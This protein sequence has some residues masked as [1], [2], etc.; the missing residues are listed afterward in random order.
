MGFFN[1][2][3]ERGVSSS[4]IVSKIKK[5]T[6]EKRVGHMGTL[7]VEAEGVLPVAFGKA[8]RLFDFLLTKDK[9][10]RVYFQFGAETDTLDYAGKVI[11]T[12]KFIP[13]FETFK[14]VL[15][16]FTGEI[17]QI[18]PKY[19]ALKVKGKCG[20]D[21]MRSGGD[22]TPKTRKVN[23]YSFQNPE[24]INENTYALTVNCSAGTYIRSL[25][26]DIAHSVNSYA[27][28]SKLVRTKSGC[29]DIDNAALCC[30]IEKNPKS[31]I[32]PTDFP[33]AN[34]QKVNLTDDEFRL[35][36]NGVKLKIGNDSFDNAAAYYNGEI[37]GIISNDSS[38]V[39]VIKSYLYEGKNA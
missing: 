35:L 1:V 6:G 9:T 31:F 15:S 12:S 8:V 37:F 26:R 21:I 17:E 22:F 19:S 7:D 24:I 25:V 16:Q 13:D 18:P 5:I 14:E 3:K 39:T 28:L 34:M 2:Y 38:G 27:T 33:L 30:E 11:F 10:Y 4:K 23:I 29:F 36:K 32:I 20:Y